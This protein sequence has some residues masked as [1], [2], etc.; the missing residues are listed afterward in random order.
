MLILE[1]CS[2]PDDIQ[3][4]GET[5]LKDLDILLVD[6]IHLLWRLRAIG[7]NRRKSLLAIKEKPIQ[8]IQV[9]HK[10]LINVHHS[11]NFIRALHA[12]KKEQVLDP[13]CYQHDSQESSKLVNVQDQ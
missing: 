11:P 13:V 12:T 2:S 6:G 9:L 1:K 8:H 7:S 5:F 10:F 4:L 3:Q